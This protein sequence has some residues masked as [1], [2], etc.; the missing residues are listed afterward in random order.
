MMTAGRMLAA[1]EMETVI[2]GEGLASNL[3]VNVG[4]R[5]VLMANTK[6][7]GLNA[8]EVTVGGLFATI[9]K[10]YD[11]VAVRMPLATAQQLLR[12]NG[13]HTWVI[14]LDDTD[15][16][17]RVFAD[18]QAALPPRTYDVVPW[19]RLSDFYNKSAELFAKQ[20]T[21]MKFIIGFLI[22]LSISNTLM[23]SVVERTGE[24]GT[25][26]ALGTKR[27]DVLRRFLA[28]GMVLGVSGAAIG[29]AVGAGLAAVISRIG[30]P[31]PP[32]PGMTHGYIGE[33]LVTAELAV[34]AAVL[35]IGTTLLASLYPAWKASR[36]VIVDALRHNRA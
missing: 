33:I 18:L 36:M 24:I 9:S 28:E 3:A 7:G 22:V 35:G 8:V 4:D 20:V 1:G 11:D 31:V 17:P 30:I 6:T 23:M 21:V 10:A 5:I 26:M 15:T 19:W 14:L 32:P 27:A 2:V 16:T 25:A 13:A 29:L 34:G 12:V